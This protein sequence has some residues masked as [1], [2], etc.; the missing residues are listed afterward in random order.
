M[1]STFFSLSLLWLSVVTLAAPPET[2]KLSLS[3]VDVDASELFSMMRMNINEA[4]EYLR[5][6][7]SI[8]V[9]VLGK[10]AVPEAVR[11][12]NLKFDAEDDKAVKYFRTIDLS[13]NPKGDI[14]AM[15]FAKDIDSYSRYGRDGKDLGPRP[16]LNASTILLTASSTIQTLVHEYM[17]HL[18]YEKKKR[19]EE[20]N[21][22]KIP[23]RQYVNDYRRS[24]IKERTAIRAQASKALEEKNY[25]TYAALVNTELVLLISVVRFD[26]DVEYSSMIEEM[27]ITRF[28]VEYAKEMGL[29]REKIGFN[30]W[31]HHAAYEA[32]FESRNK[33]MD[34]LRVYF[35]S[36]AVAPFLNEETIKDTKAIEADATH[37]LTRQETTSRW[38]NS[39]LK[40]H[41]EL[42]LP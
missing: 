26:L 32:A 4:I 13:A 16:Y 7:K 21:G 35:S 8:R 28:Y 37:Y 9:V 20:V 24:V 42:S 18:I 17:H 33:K 40:E 27:D 5:T 22:K 39:Y 31:Y 41:P 14:E 6:E 15:Y 11:N 23:F 10:L 29:N 2:V 12:P 25:K 1:R 34:N 36:R 3:K 30:L 38:F 19:F